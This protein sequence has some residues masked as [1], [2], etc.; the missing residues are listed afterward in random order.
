MW[1]PV[2]IVCRDFN[3]RQ[4]A[5][6]RSFSAGMDICAPSSIPIEKGGDGMMFFSLRLGRKERAALAAI[7]C[8]AVLILAGKGIAGGRSLRQDQAVPASVGAAE[9]IEAA[10][11]SLNAGRLAF[12]EGLGYQTEEEPEEAVDVLIPERFDE[13]YENY[14]ALQR[15]QGYDLEK[16]KGKKVKRYRYRILNYP[17]KKNAAATLLVY[18]GEVLGGDITLAGETPQVRGLAFPK[19]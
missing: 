9:E 3:I 15:Q 17:E 14:N 7:C 8:G 6:G 2:I 16:Y 4:T 5:P 13:A 11:A 10:D 1:N 12:L 19:G 18:K